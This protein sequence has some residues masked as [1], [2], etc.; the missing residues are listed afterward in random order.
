MIERNDYFSSLQ[1]VSKGQY[2]FPY[3]EE[4]ENGHFQ[5]GLEIEYEAKEWKS[6][7]SQYDIILDPDLNLINDEMKKIEKL[8]S[9]VFGRKHGDKPAVLKRKEC[10]ETMLPEFVFRD[11]TN[12]LELILGPFD[13]FEEL[14]AHLN[15]IRQYFEGGSWQATISL[16]WETYFFNEEAWQSHLGLLNFFHEIDILEKI[17][18]G[19]SKTGPRPLRSFEHPF[20]G[21]MMK[22]RHKWLRK[23]M[24]HHNKGE[25]LEI[26]QLERLGKRDQSCK[27]IGSTT[28][29]ADLTAPKRVCYEIRDAHKDIELLSHRIGR[30]LFWWKRNP[31]IFKQYSTLKPFDSELCFQ[32]FG[33][34]LQSFLI[35]LFPDKAPEHVKNFPNPYFC[36]QT[37]RNWS[38]PLRNWKGMIEVFELD[39]DQKVIDDQEAYFLNG[40]NDLKDNIA[41]DRFEKM[42]RVQRLLCESIHRM[43]LYQK[44]IAKEKSLMEQYQ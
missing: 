32:A 42:T 13:K 23:F 8:K 5:F 25:M 38:Y 4:K 26:E 18:K 11:D 27:Y 44:M 3:G 20:L 24:S 21:P 36:H 35:S 34:E 43:G 15:K 6:L 16:P 31:E 41:L 29:R 40:L 28:Y 37:Y 9:V 39:I 33:A 17:E 12:N 14:K 1:V 7:L 2:L 19:L 22:K 10:A 30:L